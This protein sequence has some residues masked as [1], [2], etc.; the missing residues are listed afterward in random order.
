M[1]APRRHWRRDPPPSIMERAPLGEYPFF[2][3]FPATYKRGRDVVGRR[4]TYQDRKKE[5]KCQRRL[6]K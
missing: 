4:D 3:P 1:A 6:P 2:A 5:A